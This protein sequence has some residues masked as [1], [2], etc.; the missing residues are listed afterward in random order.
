[1]TDND[2][3]LLTQAMPR[4]EHLAVGGSPCHVRSQITFK[5]LYT[6]SHRCP[7]LTTLLIHFNPASFIAKVKA[8]CESGNVALGRWDYPSSFLCS[9]TTIDVGSI[10]PLAQESNTA[11]IMALGLLRVFPRL[12]ELEYHYLHDWSS[13]NNMIQVCRRIGNPSY[14]MYS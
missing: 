13:I 7:Q 2:V 9:V 8:D 4:L 3:D 12:E 5:S 6:I 1:L 11:C 14:S 10:Q